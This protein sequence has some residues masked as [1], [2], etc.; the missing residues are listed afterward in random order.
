MLIR[1]RSCNLQRW[2]DGPQAFQPGSLGRAVPF[3]C[4]LE[5][6]VPHSTGGTAAKKTGSPLQRA[7]GEF[8]L[9]NDPRDAVW[10]M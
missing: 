5:M 9:G 6:Q 3:E 7:R 1:I 2:P 10:G 8:C 4:P